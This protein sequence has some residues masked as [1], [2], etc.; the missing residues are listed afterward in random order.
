MSSTKETCLYPIKPQLSRF[1]VDLSIEMTSDSSDD[2]D[3]ET[4]E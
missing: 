2:S 3:I 1:G 4:H